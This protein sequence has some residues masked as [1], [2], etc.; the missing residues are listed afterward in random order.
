MPVRPPAQPVAEEASLAASRCKERAT[1]EGVAHFFFYQLFLLV[2]P[3]SLSVSLRLCCLGSGVP[4]ATIQSYCVG[5][6]RTLSDPC[7][8]LLPDLCPSLLWFPLG[9]GPCP[10]SW[11]MIAVDKWGAVATVQSL[12]AAGHLSTAVR[13]LP[14]G[15]RRSSF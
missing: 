1:F 11:C 6:R 8:D 9:A 4:E 15:H 12:A 14:G 5:G 3:Y 2:G 13:A 7:P 10:P